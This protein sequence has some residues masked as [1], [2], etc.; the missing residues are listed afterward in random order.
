M[1]AAERGI[2]EIGREI[3]SRMQNSQ[4]SVF[5][6]RRITGRLM[7][8]S[9]RNEEFK[10]QLFRLVDVLPVLKSSQEVASHIREYLGDGDNVPWL[11]KAGPRLST[12]FPWLA[13]F[14]ARRGVNQ[15]ARQFITASNPQD[16]IR[17]LLELRSD[18]L[19]FTADLLGETVVS[20]KEA[21]T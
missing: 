16:A 21:E 18:G 6:S 5:N 13:N 7:R 10:T 1:D 2:Q 12:T 15:I 20:E 11:L 3:F 4:A 8:W 9:M 17:R 14:A 19:A